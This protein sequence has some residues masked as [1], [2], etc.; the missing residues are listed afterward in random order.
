MDLWVKNAPNHR[1]SFVCTGSTVSL[2][3]IFE[4]RLDGHENDIELL[5]NEE[6]VHLLDHLA[7]FI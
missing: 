4:S 2:G 5:D 7:R 3:N 6:F 1:L